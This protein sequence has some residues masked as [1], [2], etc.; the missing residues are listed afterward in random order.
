MRRPGPKQLRADTPRD[1]LLEGKAVDRH[2]RRRSRRI[3][4][5]QV[6]QNLLEAHR[7]KAAQ[8]EAEAAQVGGQCC[9]ELLAGQ[10]G[11]G[12]VDVE[13][14]VSDVAQRRIDGFPHRHFGI[15]GIQGIDLHLPRGG[16]ALQDK[17]RI[18]VCGREEF[19]GRHAVAMRIR[20]G[21]C[22]RTATLHPLHGRPSVDGAQHAPGPYGGGPH[23]H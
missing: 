4:I 22:H 23:A 20:R 10:F 3:G 5:Y 13:N 19:A 6:G 8:V 11:R 9:Q 17:G 14:P 18:A 15:A 21:A 1:L 12:G 16:A 2:L 7:R